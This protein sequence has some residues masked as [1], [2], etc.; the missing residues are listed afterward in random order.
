MKMAHPNFFRLRRAEKHQ[1]VGSRA[2]LA[3]SFGQPPKGVRSG[4][5]P[6]VWWLGVWVALFSRVLWY[7]WF[8]EIL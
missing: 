5:R 3:R 2:Q 1:L 4:L 7:L 6:L 8:C